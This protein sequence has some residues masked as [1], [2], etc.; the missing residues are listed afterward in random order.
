MHLVNVSCGG[1]RLCVGAYVSV[2][3]RVSRLAVNG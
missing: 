2:Q 3:F 1:D